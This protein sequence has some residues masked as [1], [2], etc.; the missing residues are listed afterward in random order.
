MTGSN[1]S[2]NA[3]VCNANGWQFSREPFDSDKPVQSCTRL[4]PK[5]KENLKN[6]LDTFEK[7]AT[8][9]GN[10]NIKVGVEAVRGLDESSKH[11]ERIALTIDREYSTIT[12]GHEDLKPLKTLPFRL[13]K[14]H[15]NLLD[16]SAAKKKIIEEF[17]G[18]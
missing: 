5:E 9:D 7:I 2:F 3:R 6:C 11:P 14:K 16:S 17:R 10:D 15:I 18:K 13:L 1:L 12:N 4:S 8:A